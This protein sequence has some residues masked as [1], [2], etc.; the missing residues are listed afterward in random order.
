MC[1]KIKDSLADCDESFLIG[2]ELTSLPIVKTFLCKIHTLRI[3]GASA[4]KGVPALPTL[5]LHL[6]AKGLTFEGVNLSLRSTTVT[7]V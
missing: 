6:A 5:G 4:A 2:P 3:V 7:F 1:S